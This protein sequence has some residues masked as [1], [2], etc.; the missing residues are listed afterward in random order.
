MPAHTEGENAEQMVCV[1]VVRRMLM[2]NRLSSGRGE[3][4]DSSAGRAVSPPRLLSVSFLTCK[5]ITILFTL[6]DIICANV[7]NKL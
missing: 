2:G 3:W 4:R 7:L 6:N 1:P 5:M